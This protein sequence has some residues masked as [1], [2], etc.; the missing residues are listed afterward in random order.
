MSRAIVRLTAAG[1]GTIQGR[2]GR[3]GKTNNY[4]SV[5]DSVCALSFSVGSIGQAR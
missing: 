4:D 5:W 1:L 3:C 2:G